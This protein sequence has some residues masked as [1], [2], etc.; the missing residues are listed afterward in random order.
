MQVSG[1]HSKA[2]PQVEIYTQQRSSRCSIPMLGVY[3]FIQLK[4]LK[5]MT[6]L[7][8]RWSNA[9]YV[10][11]E[12]KNPVRTMKIAGPLGLTI[13]GILYMF[14]NIAYF[15]SGTPAQIKASSTT[16]AARFMGRV[17]GLA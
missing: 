8:S 14:A 6:D 1:M 10:L 11:K 13:C 3:C 17:F 16:V 12:V 4:S 15:A 5:Y 7:M 2:L 9:A